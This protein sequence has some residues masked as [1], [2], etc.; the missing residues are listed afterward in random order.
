MGIEA[1]SLIK[2]FCGC[3]TGP[4]FYPSIVQ[5]F[6]LYPLVA[7]GTEH[8]DRIVPSFIFSKNIRKSIDK[9]QNILH[10]MF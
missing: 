5:P 9:N 6:L 3:F 1:F 2:S 10:I 7:R 8:K 4:L